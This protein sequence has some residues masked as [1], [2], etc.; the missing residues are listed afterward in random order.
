ML[1]LSIAYEETREI[2][3]VTAMLAGGFE[4]WV[5]ALVAYAAWTVRPLFGQGALRGAIAVATGVALLLG[6]FTPFLIVAAAGVVG[7]CSFA[8]LTNHPRPSGPPP[9]PVW[10]ALRPAAFVSHIRGGCWS[11]CSSWSTENWPGWA[12]S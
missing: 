11:S 3:W 9:V 5:V 1:S 4:P 6:R 10:R 7:R 12:S 8:V 2:D